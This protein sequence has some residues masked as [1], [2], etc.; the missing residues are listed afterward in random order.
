MK[1][2]YELVL[3]NGNK[4][5]VVSDL[6]YEDFIDHTLGSASKFGGFTAREVITSDSGDTSVTSEYKTAIRL[7]DII[8]A[9]PMGC[10]IPTKKDE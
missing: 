10:V 1:Y 5:T 2:M 7:S 4:I 9:T 8:Q 6:N 3:R